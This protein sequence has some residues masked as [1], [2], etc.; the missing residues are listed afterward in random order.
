MMHPPIVLPHEPRRARRVSPWRV[1]VVALLAT[2]LGLTVA[3]SMLRASA[4]AASSG[5]AP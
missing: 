5:S 1:V 3:G 2:W 4:P